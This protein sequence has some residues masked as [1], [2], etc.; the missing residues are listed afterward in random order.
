MSDPDVI[1]DD[2]EDDSKSKVKKLKE[3]L[4]KCK[5][6][7]Q[8]FLDGWQR[9]KADYINLKKRSEQEKESLKSYAVESVILDVISLIDSFEMAFKDKEAWN[10]A[11][12]NWR[13]G[14]EFIYSQACDILKKYQVEVMDPL[15]QEF[16]HNL[17]HSVELIDVDDQ[18]TDNQIVEVVQK[19]YKIEERI[20]R[21]PA[22][23]VGEYKK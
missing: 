2:L 18:E 1:Y 12:E 16:D 4:N 20:I 13:Q 3:E 15:N 11:P 21:Y 9:S 14:I 7:R 17:H 22:V 23:K 10:Q 19:G 8:E 5:E 6:E